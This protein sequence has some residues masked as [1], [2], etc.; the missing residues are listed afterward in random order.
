MRDTKFRAWD[1]EHKRMITDGVHVGGDGVLLPMKVDSHGET[2]Y[3]IVRTLIPLQYTGLHDNNGKKIYEGDVLSDID[4]EPCLHR[5]VWYEDQAKFELETLAD[6]KGNF[7]SGLWS[8]NLSD[9]I[10]GGKLTNFIVE[11]NIYEN[12]ELTKPS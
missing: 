4:T 6:D 3:S 11:G 2:H 10:D 8:D 9:L 7:E 1:E 5:I 12:P